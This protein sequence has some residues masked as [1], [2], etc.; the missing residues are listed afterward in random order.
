MWFGGQW[1][2]EGGRD[3]LIRVKHSQSLPWALDTDRTRPTALPG[4]SWRREAVG[5]GSPS[6]L[7]KPEARHCL[8]RRGTSIPTSRADS[9][10]SLMSEKPT[11]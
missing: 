5:T 3:E 2:E 6:Q 1:V 9:L 11:L 7:S 10:S 8:K 4:G